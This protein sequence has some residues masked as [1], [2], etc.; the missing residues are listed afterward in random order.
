MTRF[1]RGSLM[2]NNGDKI[3]ICFISTYV[4][5]LFDSECLSIHGGSELQ[6]YLI[7]K[8]L[9]RN[10][11]F[12]ISF[13]T[14]DFGQKNIESYE[15]IKLFK[16]FNP[17]SKDG[18]LQKFV[19]S[20]QYYRLF[21]R[22]N[23]DIYFTSA[24]NSTVGLVSFFCK[25]NNKKHIH[26]TA[27]E[28]E[29]D[30]TYSKKGILG[31]IFIKGLENSDLVITQNEIHKKLLKDN[32]DINAKVMRNSFVIKMYG[33]SEKNSFLWVSRCDYLKQPELFIKLAKYL[34]NEQFVMIAPPASEKEDYQKEI[35]EKADTI[36]NLSFIDHVPFS[37]IQQYF[38]EAKIFVNTSEYEGFPNTFLQAGVGKTPILSL[39]VN[40]D[41]FIN[42][43][44]C[45]FFCGNDFD[46]LVKN[47]EV[48]IYNKEAWK[49]KSENIFKYV[50][51]NHEIHK[52]VEQ[53][54]N[55]IYTLVE[56]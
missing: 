52:N 33:T 41:D 14:G 17:R 31:K 48:L 32:H 46:K 34:P 19:Q 26:R 45:G 22:I 4:Y 15:N 36:K 43:Y 3:K 56:G 37:K 53:L 42:K 38:N 47:V 24:A 49:E 40:P 7:A 18:L 30:L 28:V 55:C 23:A 25:L 50:K 6:L 21:K 2:K 16:S 1:L 27:S 8:E 11:D 39:N 13:V 54:T 9:S 20:I 35:K 51:E 29:V 12:E 5:P 10:E 44:N